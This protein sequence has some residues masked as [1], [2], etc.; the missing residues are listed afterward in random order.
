MSKCSLLQRERSG[1]F[2]F[3][4]MYYMYYTVRV[5]EASFILLYVYVDIKALFI[6]YQVSLLSQQK[7]RRIQT[8][9]K[10]MHGDD[11]WFSAQL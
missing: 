2:V 10:K 6:A 8:L 1:S 5:R 3:E 7:L 11:H 4:R 9:G